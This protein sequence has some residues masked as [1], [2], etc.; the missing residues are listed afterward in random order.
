MYASSDEFYF[1][2][3][4]SKSNNCIDAEIRGSEK[5]LIVIC[6]HIKGLFEYFKNIYSFN[7]K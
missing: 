3:N 7:S 4:G 5:E 2:S 1:M 6:K